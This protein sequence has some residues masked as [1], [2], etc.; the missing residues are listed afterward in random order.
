[1]CVDQDISLLLLNI[2]LCLR[3][4]SDSLVYFLW[5][6]MKCSVLALIIVGFF[7][8]QLIVLVCLKRK[9]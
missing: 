1:M 7:L 4:G 6:G 2:C 5:V 3:V 9:K 8:G